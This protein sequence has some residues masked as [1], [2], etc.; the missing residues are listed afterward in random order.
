MPT[1][2]LTLTDYLDATRW[3]WVLNDSRGSFLADHDVQL[4][5]T[6][7]EYGGFLDL[8][9]Y[10]DYHQ[11][12]NPPEAQLAELGAW[13][14]DQVFGGLRDAL[15]QNRAAPAVAVQVV[16]PQAAKDLLLRPFELARFA[17]GKSFREAGVRFVYQLEGAP[18]PT[19]AKPPAE[20]ALRILAAFSL[21]V[22]ANPLNLRRE[23]YGLQRL[24]RDLKQTR[25]LGI[26]LRVLQYGATRD[27][28]Q[29]AMEEGEGWDIIHL[30]G[31]GERG[32]LLLEDDSGGS[33]TIDADEL[34]ELLDPA[35]AR[36]KL[37]IL[38][39]CYSGAGSHLAARAQ[40]GLDQ[41]PTRQEGAE[42]D[43]L[44]ET[45]QTA[46]PSLAQTLSQRLDCA[47]L[48]MRYPVGDGFA[49]EL[50]LS[51]Y[52]KLLERR[53]PLPAAL[54][55]ALDD[56]LGADVPRPPLS[57]ATPVLAGPRAADLLLAPPQRPAQDFV[58]PTVGLGIAFP[59]EPE[60]FVGRLQ[61]MLRASQAL[62]PRSDKRGVLFYGMPGAGKT[63]CAL[64]LAYRH[65]ERRFQG[66]VWYRAPE[67]DSDITNALFNLM[68]DIQTQLNAPQ[69]G[70]TT[71]LDDPEHFRRSTLPRLRALL[72][73]NS[74][75]LALDNL[76]TLLT[77]SNRWRDSLWGDLMAALLSH[78]GS[79]RVVLTSRRRPDDLTDHPTLQVEPIHALSFAESVLLAREL[80][81]L[82][83]LFDDEG[84][85][86]LL[87]ETLRVVQGH[88]K[89][90]ELTDSLAADRT[91]LA[92]R[93][94]AVA[95]ELADRADVLD[96]FFAVGVPREGETQQDDADFVRALQGWTSRIAAGLSPTAGLLLAFLCRMEPGDRQQRI[97]EANW[98]DL[99]TRL[100]EERPVAAAALAEPEQGLPA[101][102]AALQSAGL[103]AV[104]RPQFDPAQMAGL[105]E[106]L[107]ALAG[108][109]E[110]AE[111]LDPATLL[112]GLAAQA[113]TYTIHPGVAEA[114]RAAA[115][116]AVLDA[117]DV[118][119]G[120]FH[121]AMVQRGLKSE[122]EGG[123]GVVTASARR[124]APYLLRQ[125]RWQEASTLLE[126]ML[127]R[128]SSPD[129]LAFALPLLRR[130]AEATAG[131]KEGQE[132]AGVLARTLWMAGR[133]AEAEQMMR[134]IVARGAAQGDYRLASAA[135]GNLLNLL[136]TSGRLAE[137]LAVAEEMAGY[138]RQAG[139][140]PWT[141]LLAEGMRL[142]VLADMGRYDEVL[143]EV[144][145]LRPGMEALPLER[146]PSEGAAE[147]S[148]NPW[149]VRE[150]LLD[151]GH[152]AAL[153][154]ERWEKALALNAEIVEITQARG[155]DALGLAH[156]RF[157]DYGP[158]LRLGRTA[159][160]RALLL[161]CRAVYE[162][163]R[164][165]PQLGK[166]YTALADLEDETGGR[167]AA[168]RFQEV[169]L[170]YMYQAGQPEDCAIS[171]HN[172]ANYL[173]RQGADP[174]AVLAHRLA[175][176]IIF[177]Q[178]QSGHLRTVL[179]NLAK[180]D[181]PSAPPPFATVAERVEAVEGVRFGA[182]FERLPTTVP[183]GDAALAAVW[184]LVEQ[185]KRRRGVEA[186]R[187]ET[188]LA[189]LPAAV[190]A[191]FELDG[192]EFS[193]ALR[194]ALAELPEE[195]AEATLRQ[196]RDADLIGGST[197]PDME[198]V[199]REF[200]PRLQSIAAAASD[201]SLRGEIE[202]VLASLEEKG[203]MLS[204]AARRIWAGERD[205]AALTEGLD[206]QDSA[207]VRRVLQLLEE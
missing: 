41:T 48:A 54:H 56:A 179:G 116:P 159:D 107:A 175:A 17:D 164:A 84:G 25:G 21:P 27:V 114:A 131:I 147:E 89:L 113:T 43:P 74:L 141:Q 67:A 93:V 187:Q 110:Q 16:V 181:L 23:R 201:E 125:A 85:L 129:S 186:Q 11:P 108:Q 148:V 6:S 80:P 98:E 20:N 193:T 127:Q 197:G 8:S 204:D 37:L 150:V 47:A 99:L 35:R 52:E 5:P 7:R 205:V 109:A 45:V 29:D 66:Y 88:P 190:R 78:G 162:A 2:H 194:A 137:A 176:A 71:A 82:K 102:L 90:L 170:G 203:W 60:R 153:Y 163:E 30:S 83:R 92:Q 42:G 100:G 124:A 198:Q 76:E 123:G 70:L 202:P 169:A 160:A 207:L 117:A 152:T 142:Q 77:A 63:A 168:V 136:R 19:R 188:V 121:I 3:R 130:I 61:P 18:D 134:D 161:E 196:L 183:D 177:L 64:E 157:N 199:L 22:R 101:A 145:A 50:M 128:D 58:L 166:V 79:S 105:P 178:T 9:K 126:R 38:D 39:A 68:Q 104:E 75:L 185:E 184:Q 120:N 140:G 135:A 49:T 53:Q 59:P 195:E 158:L 146:A 32:E 81:H 36:L 34:G 112:A 72:Q 33:D 44:S 94:A 149:N 133:T 171:H 96:A 167:A 97:V 13:I 10:L 14:G 155:A 138:M 122:M 46:L 62:A 51:L 111:G 91:A 154:S 144:E 200:E 206:E 165:V 173:E 182:L 174:A 28:L 4:D 192:E 87:R 132:N 73:Q 189:S 172:L 191:A 180:S 57:P 103:V 24:V 1:L 119:L 69:L 139:L 26:E 31:H 65:A 106:M 40:V 151:T 143:A 156:T 118:E 86:A 55:L 12:I 115:E 15:W 95:D